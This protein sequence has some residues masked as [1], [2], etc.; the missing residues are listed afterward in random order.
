MDRIDN[1]ADV[2]ARTMMAI[3]AA[4]VG[5]MMVHI[6]LDV[7]IRVV[8]RIPVY[9]TIEIISHYMMVIVA[10]APVAELQRR[11]KHLFVESFTT[12]LPHRVNAVLDY[13]VVLYFLALTGIYIFASARKAIEKTSV[14]ASV[15]TPAFDVV[16]WPSYWTIPIALVALAIVLLAQALARPQTVRSVSPESAEHAWE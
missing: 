9:G 12:W 14:N 8:L 3:G 16:I 7:A 1:I 11:R 10:F 4:A 13:I 6:C 2:A 5:L 15:E